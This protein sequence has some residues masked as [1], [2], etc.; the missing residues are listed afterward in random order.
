MDR[1]IHGVKD[2]DLNETKALPA[3]AGTVNSDGIDLGALSDRGGRFL[4]CEG[5]LSAP[6]LTTGELPDT[7]TMTYTIQSSAT[8]NFASAT[9][10][11]GSCIVQTGDTGADAETFRFKIPSNCQ[12]Y[13][14]AVA[15]GADVGNAS[16]GNCAASELTLE[17]LF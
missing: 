5:L 6:A 15:V 8:S 4:D 16:L 14:R 7:T 2:A 1:A 3:A 12:R 17:L 11:A 13:I 9:T 10:L